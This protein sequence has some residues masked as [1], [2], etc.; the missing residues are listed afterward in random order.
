MLVTYN[1]LPQV[2][3]SIV[4]ADLCQG[5]EVPEITNT[6]NN[7]KKILEN[8]CI[9]NIHRREKIL[10]YIILIDISIYK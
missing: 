7:L 10:F 4:L 9:Y 2:Q 3:P 5:P 8:I 6:K 1:H